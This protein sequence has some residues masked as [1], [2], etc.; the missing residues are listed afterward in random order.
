LPLNPVPRS[1]YTNPVEKKSLATL[2]V[3]FA[4]NART[5]DADRQ[6][7]FV[8]VPTAELQTSG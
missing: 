1:E 7:A 2:V 4:F 5:K 8:L 6:H 3:N